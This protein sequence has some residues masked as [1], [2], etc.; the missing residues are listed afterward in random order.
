MKQ[1]ILSPTTGGLKLN[2]MKRIALLLLITIPLFSLTQE[3]VIWDYPVKPGSVEW[4]KLTSYQDRLNAYNIHGDILK[5]IS[6]EELAKT[7][8]NYPEFRLIFTR[9]NMQKGYDYIRTK[10]NGF[11]EL[12]SRSDAGKELLKLYK[13]YNPDNFNKKSTNLEIGNFIVKF[14]YIELLIAQNEILKS[15]NDEESQEL[16]LQ[17]CKKYKGKK[18]LQSYYGII[19]LKTTALIL[20]RNYKAD[21]SKIKSRFGEDKFASFINQLKVVDVKIIDEVVTECDKLSSDG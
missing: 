19:G 8:L 11:R 18:N 5:R 10:F 16:L 3:K 2:A 14:T 12:E 13:N 6:T 9:N 7:C 21:L 4:K 20:A 15:F 1:K 17:C